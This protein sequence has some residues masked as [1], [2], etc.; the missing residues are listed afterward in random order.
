MKGREKKRKMRGIQLIEGVGDV[1]ERSEDCYYWQLII[2]LLG[3]CSLRRN[4]SGP[5]SM[6]DAL[7]KY[8]NG[9]LVL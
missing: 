3:G 9:N 6:S 1:G 2:T 8:S 7:I 4:Y 5:I